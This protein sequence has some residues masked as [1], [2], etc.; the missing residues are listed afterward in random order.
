MDENYDAHARLTD[1]MD[2][3][4]GPFPTE[5]MEWLLTKL[6]ECLFQMRQEMEALRKQ[7]ECVVCGCSL[8]PIERPHCEDC[9]DDDE[10]GGG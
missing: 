2:E 7:N 3:A 6:E 10:E 9:V 5:P 1:I 8:L 4:F